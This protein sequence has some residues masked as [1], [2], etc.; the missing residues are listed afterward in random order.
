LYFQKQTGIRIDMT[1]QKFALGIDLGTTQSYMAYKPLDS[2]DKVR[3]I[4][5]TPSELQKAINCEQDPGQC[6]TPSIV[7]INPQAQAGLPKF[8]LKI[9]VPSDDDINPTYQPVARFKSLL[10]KSRDAQKLPDYLILGENPSIDRY[11]AE[12]EAIA[13]FLLLSMRSSAEKRDSSFR[14]NVCDVTLTVPALSSIA[15]RK[16]TL[17]AARL[18]G[19]TGE[20]YALEEPI[21]AFLHHYYRRN[22]GELFRDL[23]NP[24]VLVFDFGG[25]TCDAS[26]I[27]VQ[28][29][30][31]PI[32]EARQAAELGG[33]K[34]DELIACRW[35]KRSKKT[36][37]EFGDLTSP[38]QYALRS[39]ARKVKENLARRSHDSVPIGNLLTKNRRN[40]K[41]G[42][43]SLNQSVLDDILERDIFSCEFE[44][45][46]ETASVK[47]HIEKL[48][49]LL[50]KDAGITKNRIGAVIFAGGS[51]RL[52]QVQTWLRQQFDTVPSEKF[53]DQDMEVS[54]AM[55]AV[56]HQYYRHHPD[57]RYQKLIEPTLPWDIKLQHSFKRETGFWMGE[58]ILA[59]RN[60]SL[61]INKRFKIIDG[62]QPE[63]NSVRV[64]L[65]QGN[66]TGE[67]LL[68]ATIKVGRAGASVLQLTYY[69]NEYGL[70][71]FACT[72]GTWWYPPI[73]RM[74]FDRSSVLRKYGLFT[75]DTETIRL[76]NDDYDLGNQDRIKR[77]RDIYGIK[78][79][80]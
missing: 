25:G 17:F 68:D 6:A 64:R 57:A 41:I 79:S 60:N 28:N 59:A 52:K 15:Q 51:S 5:C 11:Y 3:L 42:S 66:R 33:E 21:A 77:L 34:I 71:D 8:D 18:A 10:G 70:V 40:I 16:A 48:L 56:V 74:I 78:P 47:R 53:I 72:P 45:G 43:R 49:D 19:F 50:L 27:N 73:V 12:P 46:S 22:D 24:Y 14:A 67:S 35:L 62:V 54:I 44:H 23:E 80:R 32:V 7:F 13:G 36:A 9:Q 37:V 29:G 63:N 20:L 26:I 38:S 39:S 1:Q 4:N 2:R 65:Y 69:I 30:R 75:A 55:G 76:V 61:P 58:E 31:L